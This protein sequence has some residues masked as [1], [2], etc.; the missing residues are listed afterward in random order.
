M[1]ISENDFASNA[2]ELGKL[3]VEVMNLALSAPAE[4]I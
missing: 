3:L 2:P 4:T 1:P